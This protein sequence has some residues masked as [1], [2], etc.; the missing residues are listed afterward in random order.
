MSRE[1]F[2]QEGVQLFLGL[3]PEQPFRDLVD[4]LEGYELDLCGKIVF[5]QK[6]PKGR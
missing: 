6:S 1:R 3:L 5:P 4:G 2:F